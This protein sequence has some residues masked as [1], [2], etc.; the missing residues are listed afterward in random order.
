MWLGREEESSGDAPSH[1]HTLVDEWSESVGSLKL[2]D[3]RD[4]GDVGMSQVHE[5]PEVAARK[6]HLLGLEA[7]SQVLGW[8]FQVSM[9][10]SKQRS[11]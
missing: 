4:V 3:L 8:L 7:R 6:Q 11:Y 1:L 10:P 2:D 5:A 9:E